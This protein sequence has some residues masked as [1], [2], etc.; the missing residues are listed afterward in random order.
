MVT[1]TNFFK[2]SVCGSANSYP[3]SAIWGTA[4]ATASATFTTIPG[5]ATNLYGYSDSGSVYW[6]LGRL[7]VFFNTAALTGKTILTA[8]LYLYTYIT[9]T[10][11]LG[12]T[13]ISLVSATTDND[14][15]LVASDFSITNFG[16]TEFSSRISL[17]SMLLNTF[18]CFT[19]NASGLSS[20]N[21]TGV[22]KF[23]IL[24]NH[25]I[26]NSEPSLG[27]YS[28]RSVQFDIIG[29][30]PSAQ[31]TREIYLEVTYATNNNLMLND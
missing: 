9:T 16:S 31:P 27:I 18:S 20:I 4:R 1:R 17:S 2:S 12:N 26:D 15:S 8:K 23:G 11:E 25:D 19:L 21:K 14:S 5:V 10:D 28:S 13:S 22:T 3:P 30:P 24:F 6:R 7:A 29:A